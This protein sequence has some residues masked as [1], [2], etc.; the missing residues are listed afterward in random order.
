[1]NTAGNRNRDLAEPISLG[2]RIVVGLLRLLLPPLSDNEEAADYLRTQI[3][4]KNPAIDWVIVRPDSL[5]NENEVSEYS[6]LTSPAR[7]ALFNPGK[8][9]RINVGHFLASL[10]HDPDLWDQ[11]KGQMPVIYNLETDAK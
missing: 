3:G 10:L 7:S 5:I 6:V 1:M 11:W 4:Q 2:E 8:T 9:S